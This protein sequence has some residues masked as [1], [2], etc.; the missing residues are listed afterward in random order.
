M[1]HSEQLLHIATE[2]GKVQRAERLHWNI[3]DDR[4]EKARK[5]M[6]EIEK[7]RDDKLKEY[8]QRANQLRTELE[9]LIRAL[10]DP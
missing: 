5:N 10:G 1:N 6:K 4:L 3:W 7:E 2:L 9:Q 8:R